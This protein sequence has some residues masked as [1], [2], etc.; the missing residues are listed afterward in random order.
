MESYQSLETNKGYGRQRQ[1]NFRLTRKYKTTD[2]LYFN[3]LVEPAYSTDG[4][5]NA[6]YQSK[7][8]RQQVLKQILQVN[9]TKKTF[10]TLVRFS[11]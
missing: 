2:V 5:Q 7:R 4:E 6:Q 8:Q 10:E 1:K 11:F 3:Q 9:Q